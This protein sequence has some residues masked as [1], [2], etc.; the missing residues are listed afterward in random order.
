MS[1]DMSVSERIDVIRPR[2]DAI[3]SEY[4][5]TNPPIFKLRDEALELCRA[6]RLLRKQQLP[7]SYVVVHPRN[8]YGDGIV[9]EQVNKLVDAFA[10]H[11]FSLNEIGLPL[12]SEVPPAA[13]PR[14]GEVKVFNEAIVKDAQGALPPIAEEEYSV[15]SV[16]KSHSSMASRCVIF[17]MPHDN[18]RITDGGK[19]NLQKSER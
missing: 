12:A 5:G 13:N 14:G 19:L 7:S 16:A 11:G 9:P 3:L 8:R 4:R 10:N 1:G 6:S 17:E 18:A 15:V 2:M